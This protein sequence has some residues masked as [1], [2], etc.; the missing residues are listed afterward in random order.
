M[1]DFDPAQDVIRIADVEPVEEPGFKRRYL[2]RGERMMV[3][4]SEMQ[5]GVDS[6]KLPEHYR[7]HD[8]EEIVFLFQGKLLYEDG[9]VV[10]GG[11]ITINHPDQPHGCK[12]VG[13]QPVIALAIH[14]PPPDRFDDPEMIKN[15]VGYHHKKR[16]S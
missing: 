2:F 12:V 15:F 6:T 3:Y 5:P 10:E 16:T 14:A 8:N 13:D 9:R 11:M 7:R 1:A 4:Y